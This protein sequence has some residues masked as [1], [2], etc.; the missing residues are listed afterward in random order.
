VVTYFGNDR[1]ARDAGQPVGM[2]IVNRQLHDNEWKNSTQFNAQERQGIV[3]H[4][5]HTATGRLKSETPEA[6]FMTPGGRRCDADSPGAR[7]VWI[8]ATVLDGL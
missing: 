2:A 6:G 4:I 7:P 3:D 1:T 5:R 8:W